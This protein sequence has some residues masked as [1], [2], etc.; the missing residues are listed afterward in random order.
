MGV[1]ATST[2][3]TSTTRRLL[4]D[5]DHY[6]AAAA[7]AADGGEAEGCEYYEYDG[8]NV[9]GDGNYRTKEYCESD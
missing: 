3:P 8:L 7:A 6:A 1:W 4:E 2:Y 5:G 9:E